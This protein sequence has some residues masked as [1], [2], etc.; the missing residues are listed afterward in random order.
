MG[1]NFWWLST[2]TYLLCDKFI[3]FF[4][5]MDEN[6]QVDVD[7]PMGRNET[8]TFVVQQDSVSKKEVVGP[9]NV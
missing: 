3:I 5:E 9:I 6:P 2:S 1:F 8:T 4:F 7:D